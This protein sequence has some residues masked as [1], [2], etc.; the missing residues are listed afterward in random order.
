METLSVCG[1]LGCMPS[2]KGG[3]EEEC[4]MLGQSKK[5]GE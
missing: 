4:W 2:G 1:C 5:G 3:Q